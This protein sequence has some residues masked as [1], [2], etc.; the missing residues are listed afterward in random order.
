MQIPTLTTDRLLLLPPSAHAEDPY[1]HGCPAGRGAGYLG[2]LERSRK[3]GF[4]FLP[5]SLGIEPV[6]VD[7]MAYATGLSKE[8]MS[9][10]TGRATWL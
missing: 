4:P 10:S 3:T 5:G 9:P 8:N 6:R 1:C 2:S 7:L